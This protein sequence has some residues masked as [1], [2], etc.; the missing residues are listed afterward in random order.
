MS[1]RLPATISGS[2]MRLRARCPFFAVLALHAQW[3]EDPTI[4]T[5]AQTASGCASTRSLWL[6]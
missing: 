5:A 3:V 6:A 4:G 2:V 1:A